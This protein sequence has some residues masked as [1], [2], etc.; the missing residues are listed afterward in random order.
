MFPED[1]LRVGLAIIIS[2][3]LSLILY[4]LPSTA[5]RKYYSLLLGAFLQYYVYGN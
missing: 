1:Q 4:K 5:I 3:P 2:I